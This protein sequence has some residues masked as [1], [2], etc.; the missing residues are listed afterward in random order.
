MV[1]AEPTVHQRQPDA[2]PAERAA[3]AKSRRGEVPRSCHGEWAPPRDRPDPIA[4]LELS[5]RD[6]WPSVAP[7][8][9]GRMLDSPF[10]F[11]RGAAVV[12]AHDMTGTPV[13]GLQVQ[14]CGDAHLGNFGGYATPERNLV[15]DINDFDET[16]PGPWEGD[17][18][19]LATS[20]IVLG[21]SNGLGEEA[22]RVAAETCVCAYR[23]HV[24]SY[25][26]MPFLDV[27]YAAI[28]AEKTIAQFTHDPQPVAEAFAKA[29][30]RTNLA[31]LPKLAERV[32]G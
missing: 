4:L 25:G 3:A 31:T 12:M 14:L 16:W 30:R 29:R 21:R 20:A 19:R 10:A 24:Q 18:K 9:Y 23:E 22:C 7:L 11:L 8:R 32:G 17:I 27:W 2:P 5:Q 6:R 28:D 26:E 15:F 1:A 13:S